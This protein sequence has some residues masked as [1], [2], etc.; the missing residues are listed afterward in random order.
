M[1]LI[2][3]GIYLLLGALAG[4][5]A[6]LLGVGGGLI[7]VPVLAWVF[8]HQG[9][10]PDVIMHMA[11]ATSLATIALT[12]L[13]SMRAHHKK[14]AV[15]WRVFAQLSPG[16]VLGALAGAAIA[17]QTPGRALAV[18]FGL[19]ELGVAAQLIMDRRPA[20]GRR[21][22]GRVV[23]FV[24]GIGIGLISAIV[25]IGGG[26]LTVPWLIWNRLTVQEAVATSS[27]CGFPIALAGVSGFLLAGANTGIAYS[28][29][30][31]Y[32]PAFVVVSIASIM[33]APLGAS[34]AHRISGS[35]LKRGFAL[36]LLI[37][38]VLMLLRQ[39]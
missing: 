26:T 9:F 21:L 31:I 5:L 14:D 12:S 22:A 19:F 35:K 4:V 2:A 27:A 36:F 1:F 32:W 25:G 18:F 37:I 11:I 15:R 23:Q 16:I 30:Y 34:L 8:A 38:G 29:S 33:F 13:S 10:N 3:T 39:P 7:I 24:A 28:S 6:G 20:P 17:E